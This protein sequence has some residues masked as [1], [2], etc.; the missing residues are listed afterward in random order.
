MYGNLIIEMKRKK[1]T[2]KELADCIGITTRGIFKKLHGG[3]FYHSETV[4]IRDKFFPDF[5][6][7]KLFE[8]C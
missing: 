7:E 4:K 8:R 3:E 2:Q 1:V 5:D 6:I